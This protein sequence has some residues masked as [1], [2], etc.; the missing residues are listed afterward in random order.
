MKQE[1]KELLLKDLCTRLPYGFLYQ[2]IY[3]DRTPQT[4]NKVV[5]DG[6]YTLFDGWQI[7]EIKPYLRPMSSMTGKEWCEYCDACA[8]DD[9]SWIIAGRDYKFIPVANREDFLNSHHFDYRGLIE[10]GLAI[11]APKDMY[12][13]D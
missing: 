11:E 6:E 8:D 3:D 4:P 2:V 1:E 10:K 12:K 13:N 7:H 5:I 9:K